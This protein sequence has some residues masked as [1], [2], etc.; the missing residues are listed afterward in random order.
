MKKH[1]T[2]LSFKKEANLAELKRLALANIGDRK[3]ADQ[4]A[5]DIAGD[6][7]LASSLK[8]SSKWCIWEQ[9][10]KGHVKSL[11]YKEL[12]KQTAVIRSVEE[13][14]IHWLN[15]PQPSSLFNSRK[16][17]R[18]MEDGEIPKA[19]DALMVF[20]E[21][22]QPEWEDPAN[23]DGGHLE[24]SLTRVFDLGEIDEIWNNL[25]IGALS[26]EIDPD[27]IVTGKWKY[28]GSCVNPRITKETSYNFANMRHHLMF[29]PTY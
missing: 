9:Y 8:L 6:K 19:L 3:F 26:G 18:I 5:K 4:E 22:I 1:T 20:K 23:S 11:S 2:Y 15:I 13:F 12:L 14:W 28:I 21:G 25:I 17:C 24:Y 7:S 29:C 27:K 16:I 10:V